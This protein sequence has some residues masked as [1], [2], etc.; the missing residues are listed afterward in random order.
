[1]STLTAIQGNTASQSRATQLRFRLL[2]AGLSA[3][4]LISITLG[5]TL[6]PVEIPVSAV[7]R[8]A[9]SETLNVLSD[10]T[11]L[12]LS[13]R[14]EEDWSKAQ[15]NIIW[16]IRFPRV[17]LALFVGAGLAVVG[18]TMQALVRNP[19]ADPYILGI[20]SGASVGAV[21]VLAFGAFAFAG[22]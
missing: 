12:D 11:A 5:I 16:L 13:G 18:V 10:I 21:A 7:W 8:I 17:L 6:G 2:L 9:A 20:S 14:I 22:I 3:L 1:M 15:F 19:L 4:L